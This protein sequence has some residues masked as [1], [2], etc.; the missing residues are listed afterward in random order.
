MSTLRV[1]MDSNVFISAFLFGGVPAGIIELA[2]GDS[3]LPD[4]KHRRGIKILTPVDFLRKTEHFTK[5]Q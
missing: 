3:H 4:L 2:L 1:V 5:K